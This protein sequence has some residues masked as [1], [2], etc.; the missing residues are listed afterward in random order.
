LISPFFEHFFQHVHRICDGEETEGV[1]KKA[2]WRG[3]MSCQ[4]KKRMVAIINTRIGCATDGVDVKIIISLRTTRCA[5]FFWPMNMHDLDVHNSMLI[6]LK[7]S[8][9]THHR[10]PNPNPSEGQQWQSPHRHLFGS[11][12]QGIH[13]M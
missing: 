7:G 5:F 10:Y 8:T 6:Q 1:I 11:L 2:R 9:D 4:N 3:S 13:K 12:P